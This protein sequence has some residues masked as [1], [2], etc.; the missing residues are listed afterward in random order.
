[1]TFETYLVWYEGRR[2]P[3]CLSGGIMGDILDDFHRSRKER[4]PSP[5]IDWQA[6][7]DKWVQSVENSTDSSRR[8]SET[9]SP[10][11][12]WPSRGSMWTSWRTSL[13]PI[14]FRHSR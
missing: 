12:M 11:R 9:P 7:K 10:P 14:R 8:C 2:L 1:M 4:A 6:K 3:G 5:K 13:A